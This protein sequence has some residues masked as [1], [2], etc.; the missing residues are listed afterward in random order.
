MTQAGI[1]LR[2]MHLR[3]RGVGP[4]IGLAGLGFTLLCFAGQAGLQGQIVSQNP[5]TPKQLIQEMVAHEDDNAAHRDRY[6]FLSQERSDRTGGHLWI[7]RVVETRD[8]RVRMLISDNGVPLNPERTQQERAR[9]DAIAADPT[10]FL[11]REASQ[12]S[13]EQHA[14]Q[15]LD[16]LPRAFLFDNVRLANGTWRMDFHPDPDYSPNG[17]EE[18]VLHGMSGMVAIDDR[19]RRIMHIEA[20]LPADVSIGFGILATIKAGSHFAS[21]RA[22]ID[23]H[24]RTTHVLTDIRGR[25][26]LFKTVAKDSEVSRSEFKYLDPGITVAQAVELLEKP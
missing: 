25:A 8:G 3:M 10:A 26:V 11:K 17:M 18:R 20:K 23:G 12:N 1:V 9:L 13:D 4:G 14:R 21:D 19:S 16:L 24:W 6:E 5:Q 7:E 2:E 22:D 15:M